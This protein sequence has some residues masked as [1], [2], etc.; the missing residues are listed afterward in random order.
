ESLDSI[1]SVTG[2]FQSVLPKASADRSEARGTGENDDSC[3]GDSLAAR[4]KSLL[5]NGSPV[6]HT[7]PALKRAGE[8]ERKSRVWAK[9]KLTRQSQ[10]SLSDWNQE[11]QGKI[12]EIKA[13]LLLRAKKSTSAKDLQIAASEAASDYSLHLEQAV[14]HFKAPTDQRFQSDQHTPASRMK[15]LVESSL[16]EAVSFHRAD[17][18]NCCLLK[19][20]QLKSLSTVPSP[21]CSRHRTAATSRSDSAAELHPLLQEEQDTRAVRS[22]AASDRHTESHLAA[23]KKLPLDACPEDI[24]KQI[25]SITFSSRKRLQSPLASVALGSSL[26]GDALDGIM[27]LEP[28][29]ASTEEESHGKQRWGGSKTSSPLSPNAIASPAEK[30][31]LY[32]VPADRNRA[33]TY[34]ETDCLS[35]QGS[36]SVHADG[37]QTLSTKKLGVLPRDEPEL[38]KPSASPVGLDCGTRFSQETNRWNE[39]LLISSS[40]QEKSSPAR[41]IQLCESLAASDPAVQADL[42]KG[43]IKLGEEEKKSPSDKV[44]L[45]WE[46]AAREQTGMSQHSPAYEMLSTTAV[47][48]SLPTKKALSCVHITLSSKC[49]NSELHSDVNAEY[50]MRSRDKP[51]V[52]TQPPSLNTPEALIEAVSKVAAADLIP[53]DQRSSSFPSAVSLADPSLVLSSVPGTAGQELPLQSNERPQLTVGSGGCSLKKLCNSEG[54]AKTGKTTSDAT[55]QITTE[56]PE[57]ITFSAEIYLNSQ[58][59]QNTLPQSA[60]QAA[61]GL[62]HKTTPSL[63]K[64]SSFTRQADQPILLPYKPSGSSGLYYVPYLKP[65]PKMPPL[66]VS[67][68]AGSNDAPPPRS[69]GNVLGLRDDNPPD[70]TASKNKGI[71]SQRAKAKL[72]WAEEQMIPLEASSE[73]AAHSKPVKTT[74]PTFKSSRFSLRGPT[75]FSES[76]SPSPSEPSED[77]CGVGPSRPSSSAV[78]WNWKKTPRHHHLFSAHPT[79]G[80]EHEFFPL[81]AEADDSRSEDLNGSTPLGNQTSGQELLRGGRRESDQKAAGNSSPCNRTARLSETVEKDLPWRQ[82]SHSGGSLAELWVK[83][84]ECQKRHQHQDSQS[85]GEL[86]LVE[87]LDRLA[88]VLQNPIKHTLIPAKSER[89]LSERRIKERERKKEESLAGSTLEPHSTPLEDRPRIT[90]DQNILVELRKSRSGEKIIHST[91]PIL[92][93]QQYLESPSDTSSEAR[94]SRDHGTTMSC[95][96]SE[97]EV[98]SA[99]QPEVS[100]SSIS[101]IDT[102]RLIRAFGHGRVR[103]S[104]RLSQLYWTINHQKK[105]SEKWEEGSGQREGVEY[106]EGASDRHRKRKEVQ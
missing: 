73:R 62:P 12:E 19:E 82:S 39:L 1:P 56:S 58:A 46:E 28:D 53:G 29:S 71:S 31:R 99:P 32:H 30:V 45:I 6:A 75:P 43:H 44:P 8:E 100:S 95:S 35:A 9:L 18:S 26:S 2:G 4:V 48:P 94:L 88:R 86:S 21:V 90:H 36:V 24:M 80:G 22:A 41:H 76:S 106:P 55:T 7:A 74:H 78:L 105:R 63:D 51:E 13:E 25:T 79:K 16:G 70:T 50:E 38:G 42:L 27:P 84:L 103:L 34:Q 96:T 14:E 52:N 81:A 69:P 59:H 20:T 91:N 104:P 61:R 67:F 40:Q 101:T 5:R 54:P 92:E 57:K 49:N 10:E 65:G 93:A 83:F 77:S 98:E 97:W 85:R 17:P 87:R 33:G 47:S 60:L 15:E 23:E 68:S 89:A 64:I 3:S 72:A 102:A 11:D 66:L 37:K